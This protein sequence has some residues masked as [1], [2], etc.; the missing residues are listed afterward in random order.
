MSDPIKF[1]QMEKNATD[2]VFEATVM[3]SKQAKQVQN[4]RFLKEQ[5]AKNA[6]EDIEDLEMVEEL[7][8]D[9]VAEI[10]KIKKSTTIALDN[11]LKGEI[12]KTE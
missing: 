5:D 10:N 2:D 1:R 4:N 7:S 6:R 3:A 8:D 12:S 9:E 11:L